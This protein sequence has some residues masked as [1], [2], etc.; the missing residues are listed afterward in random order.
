MYKWP[1]GRVIRTICLLVIGAI[2]GFG[3]MIPYVGPGVGM[4]LAL[5]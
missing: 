3:T 1:Q 5:E 2:A 4:A